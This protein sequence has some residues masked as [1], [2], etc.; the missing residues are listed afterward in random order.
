MISHAAY[1]RLGARRALTAP[2]TYRLL[3][4]LGF[5]GVAMTDSLGIVRG[6]WPVR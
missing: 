2:A 1:E 4:E 3:R 5:A 6:P